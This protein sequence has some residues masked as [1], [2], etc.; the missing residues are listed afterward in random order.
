[1]D[2]GRSLSLRLVSFISRGGVV[3]AVFESIFFYQSN[4]RFLVIVPRA[5]AMF[6]KPYHLCPPKQPEKCGPGADPK[7]KLWLNQNYVAGL[8]ST[9][10]FVLIHLIG[11]S[12]D[13]GL[14]FPEMDYSR[15]LLEK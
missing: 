5:E 15:L 1:M 14:F 10:V 13:D 7:K 12:R 9:V 6:R 3:H 4:V 8:V 2:H 11:S